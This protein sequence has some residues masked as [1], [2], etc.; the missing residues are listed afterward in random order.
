MLC[1]SNI[2]MIA[3]ILVMGYMSYQELNSVKSDR[4]IFKIS[5][6]RPGYFIASDKRGHP[7]L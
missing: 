7:I 1:Q 6:N 5:S 2:M 4:G 3:I